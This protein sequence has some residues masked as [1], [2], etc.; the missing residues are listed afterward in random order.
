MTKTGPIRT[1]GTKA[2]SITGTPKGKGISKPVGT[3]VTAKK[4]MHPV[5]TKHG[6]LRNSESYR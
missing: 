3:A 6:F 5:V 2:A 4:G 1:S